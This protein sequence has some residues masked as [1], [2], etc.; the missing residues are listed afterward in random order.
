[1]LKI[2]QPAS[3]GDPVEPVGAALLRCRCQHTSP[4]LV[5][6]C[7]HFEA[8]YSFGNAGTLV[9]APALNFARRPAA[10]L[11][12]INSARALELAAACRSPTKARRASIRSSG[13][14]STCPVLL[15]DARRSDE[16]VLLGSPARD[17]KASW[18]LDEIIGANGPT[19]CG[20][21]PKPATGGRD[22][23]RKVRLLT[24]S[25]PNQHRR[26]R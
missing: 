2:P 17:E 25:S 8:F 26:F 10:P 7:E 24:M 1:L 13:A 18:I 22:G 19:G 21:R 20:T 11:G 15:S 4:A 14:V 9:S 6:L 5:R 3:A 16:T 12:Q 23:M